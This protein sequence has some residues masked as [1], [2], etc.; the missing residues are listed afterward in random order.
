MDLGQTDRGATR[1]VFVYQQT[2]AG[3]LH[4]FGVHSYLAIAL[5]S[6]T[7]VALSWFGDGLWGLIT[8]YVTTNLWQTGLQISLFPLVGLFHK[9]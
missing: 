9:F 8:N 2:K 7:V 1:R 3:L 6:C 4:L 5:V